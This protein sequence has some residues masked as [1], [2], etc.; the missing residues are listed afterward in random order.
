M[1]GTGSKYYIAESGKVAE[2]AALYRQ[3]RLLW[4]EEVREFLESCGATSGRIGWGGKLH[5]LKFEGA[6]PDG[7]KKADKYGYQSPYVKN[8]EWIN[9]LADGPTEPQSI[10]YIEKAMEIVAH[11]SYESETSK[12][13]MRIGGFEPVQVC[14]YSEDSPL[15]VILPDVSGS[16]AER[17]SSGY[18]VTSITSWVAPD[19]LREILKEEW[20]LMAAKYKNN[21][22][23]TNEL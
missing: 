13:S 8:K 16:I 22:G 4:G 17:K 23:K 18:T 19:G 3:S 21:K 20:D 14:Y 6:T 7:F 10:D 11:L 12:G 15:L 2:E 9:R 1:Y 5:S